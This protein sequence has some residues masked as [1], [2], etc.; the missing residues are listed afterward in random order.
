MKTYQCREHCPD[1]PERFMPDWEGVD[2]IDISTPQ[3]AAEAYAADLL[4]GDPDFGAG[5]DVEVQG[6]GVWRVGFDWEPTPY[7]R[8]VEP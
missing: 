2:V 3:D 8:K 1:V 5:V 6:H 7:S 4:S